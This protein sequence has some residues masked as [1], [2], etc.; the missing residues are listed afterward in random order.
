M[1]VPR[2]RNIL[3][4]RQARLTSVAETGICDGLDVCAQ[5]DINLCTKV[6]SF[7]TISFQT[8]T[9]SF[10]T[11]TNK[12]IPTSHLKKFTLQSQS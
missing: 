10:A 5:V 1:M 4:N 8:T 9:S 11:A 7:F 12:H 2:E 3:Y 6:V